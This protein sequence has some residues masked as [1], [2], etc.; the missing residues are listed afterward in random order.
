M[1]NRQALLTGMILLFCMKG[2]S[3]S[4]ETLPSLAKTIGKSVVTILAYDRQGEMINQGKGF[5]VSTEGDVLAHFFLGMFFLEV[6]DKDHA[7]DEYRVLK[8]LDRDYANDLFQM[9]H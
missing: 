2:V 4:Q 7:L 6:G 9:I 8:D 5:F 1:K 3:S